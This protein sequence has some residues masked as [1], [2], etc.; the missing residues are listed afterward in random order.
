MEYTREDIKRHIEEYARLTAEAADLAR[1]IE[2]EKAFF[3]Q[4]AERDLADSKVKTKCYYGDSAKIT[5]VTASTVKI[6]RFEALNSLFGDRIYDYVRAE[7]KTDIKDASTKRMLAAV[8]YDECIDETAENCIN[9]MTGDERQCKLLMKKLKGANPQKDAENIRAIT[10]CSEDDA[11]YYASVFAEV[12]A[13]EE[14]AKMMKL[15][16]ITDAEKAKELIH[17]ALTVERTAKVGIELFEE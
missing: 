7:V 1:K 8:F 5:A 9:Q 11:A 16:G 4:L 2:D 12:K 14:F 6:S 15:T 17:Q 3:S 10:G 13:Y